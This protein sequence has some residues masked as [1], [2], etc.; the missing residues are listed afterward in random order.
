LGGVYISQVLVDWPAV[1]QLYL[2]L[3]AFYLLAIVL[4]LAALMRVGVHR[5]LRIGE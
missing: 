5:V 2:V 3:A 4:L 1:G